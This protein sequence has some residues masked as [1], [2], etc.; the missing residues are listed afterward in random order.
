MITGYPVKRICR[1]EP[2][3]A[4][5]YPVSGSNRKL[6]VSKTVLLVLSFYYAFYMHRLIQNVYRISGKRKREFDIM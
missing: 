4:F 2:D 3:L 1:K 6:L 5:K